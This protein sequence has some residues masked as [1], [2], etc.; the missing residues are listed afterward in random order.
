MAKIDTQQL[1]DQS[2]IF[3]VP[4]LAFLAP[5]RTRRQTEIPQ[6]YLA[7]GI[8]TGSGYKAMLFETDPQQTTRLMR[9]LAKHRKRT[10]AR[11][12]EPVLGV[13]DDVSS[14]KRRIA[15][16]LRSWWSELDWS[17]GVQD[18][19]SLQWRIFSYRGETK[20]VFN[21]HFIYHGAC[22]VQRR[23]AAVLRA[24]RSLPSFEQ[25]NVRPGIWNNTPTDNDQLRVS[26]GRK[27]LNKPTAIT[28][29]A[30]KTGRGKRSVYDLRSEDFTAMAV[31]H[32]TG[33]KRRV[34]EFSSWAASLLFTY[35]FCRTLDDSS[36]TEQ[37][38]QALLDHVHISIIDTK[39]LGDSNPAFFVPALDFLAPGCMDRYVHEYLVHDVVK[40]P[41]HKAMPLRT[42]VS[43]PMEYSAY[44]D[45]DFLALCPLPIGRKAVSEARTVGEAY[46]PTFALPMTLARLCLDK[47]DDHLFRRGV[48]VE[49]LGAVLL[50]T[51]SLQIPQDW[52]TNETIMTNIVY[53]KDFTVVGQFIR[54]MRMLVKYRQKKNPRMF[55]PPLDA[56][57]DQRKSATKLPHACTESVKKVQ[58]AMQRVMEDVEK[59]GRRAFE[60]GRETV[61]WTAD[62]VSLMREKIL[63][64]I[65]R[66][67]E[68][69]IIPRE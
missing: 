19:I 59:V 43:Q 62:M 60:T 33:G 18:R 55:E 58:A 32:L 37:K 48:P 31:A 63:D 12:R 35:T 61:I 15:N 49:Q 39:A 54:L 29:L 22:E 46:G 21:G 47:R 13:A 26:G 14:L 66:Y 11:K 30:Y 36:D 56:R 44:D 9:F 3:H 42:F 45:F 52:D 6:E 51:M 40:G 34:S 4:A 65:K 8:V 64:W 57:I 10:T 67:E 69:P 1:R 28:P 2:R 50:V 5:G 41:A 17:S 16:L 27:G 23:Y 7:H 38:R 24:V 20:R 68:Y 53:T 25:P